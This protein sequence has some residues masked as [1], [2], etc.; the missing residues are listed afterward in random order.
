MPQR[1]PEALAA[2]IR[3]V[4]TDADLAAAMAAEARRLAPDLSW[5]AVA[6]QYDALADG[7][8]ATSDPVPT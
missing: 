1:D 7:L 4:L 8:L 3:A 5:S 2:A 6:G